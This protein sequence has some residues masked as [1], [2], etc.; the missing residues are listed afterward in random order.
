PNTD[1]NEPVVCAA[2]CEAEGFSSFGLQYGIECFCGNSFGTYGL[3]GSD[4]EC[5]F[6]CPGNSQ[7]RCG[8]GDRNS[9]YDIEPFGSTPP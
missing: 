1:L 2:T 9:V 7:W 3:A 4:D 6:S 5:S 8:A